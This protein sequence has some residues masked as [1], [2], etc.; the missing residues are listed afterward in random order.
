MWQPNGMGSRVEVPHLCCIRSPASEQRRACGRAHRL[1]NVVLLEQKALFRERVDV[2]C[3]HLCAA[4][5]LDERAAWTLDTRS[6]RAELVA[7]VIDGEK[8]VVAYARQANMRKMHESDSECN[9]PPA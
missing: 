7:E 3:D 6:L 1:L 4:T 2:G 8:L 5:A 9:L